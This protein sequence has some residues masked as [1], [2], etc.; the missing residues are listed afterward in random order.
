[1]KAAGKYTQKMWDAIASIYEE[2][3]T[4]PFVVQLA[5]GTLDKNNF[6]HFLSQDI[7]YLKDDNLALDLIAEKAPNK[8][9]KQFFQMLAKDGL[10]IEKKLHNEFLT[11]FDIEE[12]QEKSPA[13]EKYTSFLLNHS[14]NSVFAIAA[15]ALLPCFWVYNSVGNHILTIAEPDNEY[16]MWIDTYRS[17]AYEQYT[18]KFIDIVERLASGAAEELLQ[19]MLKAFTQSTQYELDFF[20]EAMTR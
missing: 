5:K 18:Q 8:S 9:E 7:L 13:I 3:I 11:Y 4:H 20:E 19:E 16:Q 6:A 17:D 10:D 2:T 14:E 12:A 15:A 1:M